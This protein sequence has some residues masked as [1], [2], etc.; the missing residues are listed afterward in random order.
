VA[1][2]ITRLAYEVAAEFEELGEIR[3]LPKY[4]QGRTPLEAAL[5]MQAVCQQLS[6]GHLRQLGDVLRKA[7][8]NPKAA[9]R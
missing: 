2:E 1:L 6:P 3:L 9:P 4:L 5:L 7:V 8:A